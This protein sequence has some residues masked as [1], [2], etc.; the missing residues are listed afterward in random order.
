MLPFTANPPCLSNASN[1]ESTSI[2]TD[3]NKLR[4]HA[5]SDSAA[6]RRMKRMKCSRLLYSS[7][8]Y[9]QQNTFHSGESKTQPPP[10]TSMRF[11]H[12][13]TSS[14][15]RRPPLWPRRRRRGCSPAAAVGAAAPG[16]LWRPDPAG[17]EAVAPDKTAAVA[18]RVMQA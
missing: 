7:F 15:R 14:Q 6:D 10:M 8:Q 11:F 5:K 16:V 12:Y 2:Y 9:S 3:I 1:K 4:S 13:C 17:R 18:V